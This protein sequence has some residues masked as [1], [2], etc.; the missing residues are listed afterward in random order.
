MEYCSRCVLPNSRPNLVFKDGN[1]N[2]AVT[3]HNNVD[4]DLREVEFKEYVRRL[5]ND[6]VSQYDCVI[7]VSGGKDSTWQVIKAME[8]GLRPLAITWKSPVRTD[9]GRENLENLISL[10]VDHMDVS[11]NPEVERL[12]TLKAFKRFGSPAIPMHMAIHSIPLRIAN[13][14]N[15]RH[16]LWGENSA[17]EYGGTGLN[18]QFV[19]SEW[20]QKYAINFNT[21]HRDWVDSDLSFD[22]LKWYGISDIDVS[23]ISGS[24]LGYFFKWDPLETYRVSS[25]FGFK[26]MDKPKLGLYEFA[27]IDDK[28]LI[29]IHHYMKWFKF[30]FTRLWDNLSIEIREGRMTRAEAI[31][32]LAEQGIE[33]PE[34]EIEQFC[35]YTGISKSEFDLI[36]NS[37]RNKDI[38]TFENGKWIIKDFLLKDFWNE[39]H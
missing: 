37:F 4:W 17:V 20:M 28:F 22:D 10:G 32:R 19:T 24:F 27:D 29:V 35:Y 11:I 31:S 2:C 33:T 7:P 6:S 34:N 13:A 26:S 30:G 3:N 18:S 38:W 21:D 14:L 15:V 36:C 16:I 5:K 39:N 8:Y 23:N 12:F 25:E 1:C 9:I